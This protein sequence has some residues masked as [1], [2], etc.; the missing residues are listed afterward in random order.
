MSAFIIIS[1]YKKYMCV[2]VMLLT[3]FIYY[4]NL[5]YTY[6]KYF[7]SDKRILE[8]LKYLII[9]IIGELIL[10]DNKMIYRT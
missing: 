5:K 7:V 4:I 9:I 10:I 8:I 1:M 2:C 3:S 6:C